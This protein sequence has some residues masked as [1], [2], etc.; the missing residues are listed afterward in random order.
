MFIMIDGIDGSGKST[1]I[2]S[3]KDCLAKEG[4]AIF[5]LK[6]Y[7]LE[8]RGEFPD[9]SELKSYDFVFSCEPTY[10][11]IG[12]TIREELIKNGEKYPPRAI[13]EAY[14]LDRLILYNKIIIPLL[15]TGKCVI[16]DRGI[17]SSL[18]YQNLQGLSL[19]EIS[20]LPGNELALK[21]RPDYLVFMDLKPEEAIKRL[22]SRAEKKDDS[23]FEKEK[24]LKKLAKQFKSREFQ[25]IFLKKGTRIHRLK[26]DVKID[27]MKR[28][29][30]NL[31]TAILNR[32]G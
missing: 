18:A 20:R 3:W 27:I 24:F 32:N 12:K 4:N 25:N 19:K 14:S 10:S 11:P 26:T 22:G 8:K 23:I 6:N 21:Y 29:A 5:D 15:K 7:W 16:Q 30:T 1:V 2:Q 28:D 31:L 17:S 13:A 9:L